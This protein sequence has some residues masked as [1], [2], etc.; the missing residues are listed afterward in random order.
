[1]KYLRRFNEGND[2]VVPNRLGGEE[3]LD[4]IQKLK[5]SPFFKVSLYQYL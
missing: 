3:P 1:M 4:N 2:W 5:Y